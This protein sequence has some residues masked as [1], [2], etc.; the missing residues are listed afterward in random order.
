MLG[1][2]I[3]TAWFIHNSFYVVFLQ[4]LKKKHL[5]YVADFLL[6]FSYDTIDHQLYA[7]GQKSNAKV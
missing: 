1:L 7:V 5:L 2:F 3:K 6:F 4:C